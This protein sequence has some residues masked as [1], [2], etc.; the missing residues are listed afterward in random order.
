MTRLKPREQGAR[1]RAIYL[2]LSGILF[3]LLVGS[4]GGCEAIVSDAI[5]GFTCS[6]SDL[7]GCPQGQYCKGV[8]CAAC[9]NTDICDGFDNDCNG[10]VDDGPL[11]DHDQDGYTVC[12]TTDPSTG[13]V[14]GVDCNDNDPSVHPGAQEVCNGVDDDC[15]GIVDNPDTVCPAGKVCAPQLKQCVDQA[16]ACTP[17]NCLS[18]K[19]CD[20]LTQQCADPT[21]NYPIGHS[22]AS[23]K[24]CAS[25]LCAFP[26][27]LGG[28]GNGAVCTKLCCTSNDCDAGFICDATGSGGRYCLDATTAGRSTPGTGAGGTSCGDGTACRS[29]LC[30]GGACVD[31]CCS[32]SDCQNGTSCTLQA[33]AGH[34]GFWCGHTNGGGN[35]NQF[36]SGND[37]CKSELCADYAG[38]GARCVAPCCTSQGGACGSIESGLIDIVCVENALQDKPNDS[39]LVCTGFNGTGNAP[40]GSSCASNDDCASDN[41]DTAGSKKCTDVCCTDANCPQGTCRPDSNGALRCVLP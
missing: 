24:E 33:P 27:L 40:F 1:S 37:S 29:G 2:F 16:T 39:F 19:Q 22:C 4:S 30:T 17:Q 32:S 18:P 35:G 9:Q 13:K 15:D 7:S 12:G 34:N 5:P 8:G 28:V 38:D 23:D 25:T 11:S 31:T 41:C 10:K 26:A 3:M 21:A 20:P 6:G 36:C 14:T